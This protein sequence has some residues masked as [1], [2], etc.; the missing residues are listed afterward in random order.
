MNYFAYGSNMSLARLSA[1]IPSVRKL[2][3]GA[4]SG[5]RLMFHKAGERDGSAKCDAFFTGDPSHEVMGVVYEMDAGE[6]DRLDAI[7]GVGFGYEN[8]LV[9]VR[10]SEGV[11]VTAW[12]YC[13]TIIDSSM[14][15]FDWYLEHVVRGAQENS[16]PPDY[17][18]GILAVEAVSDPDTERASRERSIH[19]RT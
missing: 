11:V 7:E 4:V 18:G 17:I 9:E 5:Y 14:K 8:R 1:R 16:L 2:G 3:V 6:K 13:A 15:P 19:G 10:M 12:L